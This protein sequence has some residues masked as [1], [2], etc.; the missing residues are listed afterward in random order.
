MAGFS[1]KAALIALGVLLL[2]VILVLVSWQTIRTLIYTSQT[3]SIDRVEVLCSKRPPRRLSWLHEPRQ[4]HSDCPR[5]KKEL[6]SSRMSQETFLSFAYMS[7]AD[8]KT[9]S[10]FLQ[11]SRNDRNEPAKAGD[12]IVI[13]ASRLRPGTFTDWASPSISP[14]NVTRP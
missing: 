10:G 3:V 2:I 12:L 13:E 14:E 8:D 7:P 11:R 1:P 4:W 9:Y 6:G 5:L